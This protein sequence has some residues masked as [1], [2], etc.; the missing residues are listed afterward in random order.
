MGQY[1]KNRMTEH[2]KEIEDKGS[3]DPKQMNVI[4]AN[5]RKLRGNRERLLIK[6]LIL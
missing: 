1:E 3:N 2:I 4:I 5:L 6:L